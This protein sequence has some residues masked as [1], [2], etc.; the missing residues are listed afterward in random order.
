[1]KKTV[2]SQSLKRV[3][4]FIELLDYVNR[5]DYRTLGSYNVD[6]EID[7]P[8]L[9]KIIT[10]INENFTEE[11]TVTELADRMSMSPY[12]LR[13]TFKKHTKKSILQYTNELRV[14]EAC[15]LM[16][17]DQYTISY[18]SALAGFNNLSY[19]NRMFLK[20]TGQ[21]LGG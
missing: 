5:A 17:N 18:L 10:W 4:A 20:V 8:Q 6:E 19:F 1:M 21:T 9:E 2:S 12:Q 13:S 15:R 14:F 3:A 7:N 11:F 16:Q